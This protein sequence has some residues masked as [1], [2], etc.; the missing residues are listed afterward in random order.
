MPFDPS[1]N[2]VEILAS[3]G[4]SAAAA[5]TPVQ[6]GTDTSIW[7]VEHGGQ[8]SALRVFRPDQ[9]ATCQREVEAIEAAH[10][11]ELPVPA[12]RASAVWQGRPVLLLA[13]CGGVPLWEAIRRRPWRVWPL[14]MAFGRAQARIHSVAAPAQLRQEPPQWLGWGGSDD[15]QLQ[16]ALRRLARPAQSLL[17]LDYHPL[18]VLTDGTRITAVLD[19]ANARGGDPR[20][21]AARTYSILTVEP[22]TP[23]R[24]PLALSAIRRLLAAGWRRGYMQAGGDLANM[25]WFYVWAGAVMARDLAPRVSD[26]GSWWEPRHLAQIQSWASGWKQ[27]A[28]QSGA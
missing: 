22:F 12:I 13:W 3:L 5:I 16:A 24:P 14:G 6:G 1:L 11:A 18:N 7:R 17:H 15:Q 19:W 20:A 10:Q 28:E 26:P 9:A 4:V 25:A 2:P 23:G 8:L 21:D 27:R